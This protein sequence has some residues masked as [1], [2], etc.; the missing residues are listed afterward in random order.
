MHPKRDLGCSLKLAEKTKKLQGGDG[1]GEAEPKVSLN[2]GN[3]PSAQAFLL[4]PMTIPKFP[5]AE[6]LS[7][8][9][10]VCAQF[11]LFQKMMEMCSPPSFF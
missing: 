10:Y 6:H 8:A 11:S 1:D 4:C 2:W 5:P 9:S 3:I 7:L